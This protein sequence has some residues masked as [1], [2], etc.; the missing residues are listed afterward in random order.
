MKIGHRSLALIGLLSLSFGVL[1]TTSAHAQNVQPLQ[2]VAVPPCRVVDTRFTP[3]A[4]SPLIA[5]TVRA[6]RAT[7]TDFSGQG[8]T[9][10][11]CNI[12]V[13]ATSV[14]FNFTVTGASASGFLTAYPYDQNNSTQPISSVINYS[15][16]TS[17]PAIANGIAVP[18]CDGATT[19][20]T[21]DF[22]VVANVGT[23]NLVVDVVGYFSP[24]IGNSNTATGRDALKSNTTGSYNTANGSTALQFNTT[25]FS[26]TATG[27][28]ALL[29]NTTGSSNTAAGTSALYSNTTGFSNTATGTSALYSNTTGD[30]NTANG[31]G[32]LDSNTTGD[33]NTA[34]GRDAL[35]INT[36]GQGNVATGRAALDSNTTGSYNVAL[37]YG[38]GGSLTT[39]SNNVDIANSGVAGESGVIRIGTPGAQTRTLIAGINGATASGGVQ[40]FINANG[41]LGTL[42][43]SRRFKRDINNLGSLSDRL[44]KLRPVSFRYKQATEQGEHPLQYGLIAEEVAKVFP[45][46]VQYD[47]EGKP[48]TVYYHLLTPL[49]LGEVQRQQ[50]QLVSEKTQLASQKAQ[51]ASL[52]SENQHLRSQLTTLQAQQEQM[53]KLVSTRLNNLERAVEVNGKAPQAPATVLT[54]VPSASR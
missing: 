31:N 18:I 10:G 25:G 13:G 17:N 51:L 5:N 49:L 50:A 20:C 8:G 39:G 40:V 54:A 35:R 45:A 33:S 47:K 23:T 43:S 41:Q 30:S 37:G 19:A 52:R 3:G 32:A 46:L 12:P 27:S 29:S 22:Y 4:S 7:G 6:F 9:S 2:Y 44:L 16:T 21:N 15:T 38:A 24:D 14:F 42:T 48:F 53:L 11:N 34:A 28:L 1:S 36:T 26:N